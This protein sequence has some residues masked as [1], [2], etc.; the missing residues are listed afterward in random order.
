VKKISKAS[1]HPLV[2]KFFHSVEADKETIKWQGRIIAEV[3][4]GLFLVQLFD[5]IVGGESNQVIVPVSEMAYWP[6]YDSADELKKASQR[7]MERQ[8]ARE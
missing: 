2:G 7:H 3:S 8:K 5:W 1:K 6:I 4:P